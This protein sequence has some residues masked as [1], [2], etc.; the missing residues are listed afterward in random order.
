[1][2]ITKAEEKWARGWVRGIA[3]VLAAGGVYKTPEEFKKEVETI[4]KIALE[5]GE[6]V[7]GYASKWRERLL[8]ALSV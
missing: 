1:M 2:P 4:E 8:E 3:S 6:K 5:D 7:Y